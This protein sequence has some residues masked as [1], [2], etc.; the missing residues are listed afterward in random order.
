MREAWF[1]IAKDD[2][3][4]YS[5][6]VGFTKNSIKCTLIEGAYFV[7]SAFVNDVDEGLIDKIKNVK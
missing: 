5:K 3:K 4:Y 1:L 2:V 6:Y 7:K